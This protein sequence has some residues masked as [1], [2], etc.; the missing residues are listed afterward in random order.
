MDRTTEKQMLRLLA[1]ELS[2]SEA[3]QLRRRWT[4]DGELQLAFTAWRERWEALEPPPLPR[5]HPSFT[6]RVVRRA[7]EGPGVAAAPLGRSTPL[8]TRATAA[9]AL[10]GGVLVGVLLASPSQSEDWTAWSAVELT[11]AEAYWEILGESSDNLLQ[12]ELR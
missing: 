1:G 3:A 12:E 7:V 10:A 11:Q 5:V 8:W 4:S 6:N 9:L 2:E